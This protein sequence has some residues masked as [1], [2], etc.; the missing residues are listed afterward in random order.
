MKP[1]TSAQHCTEGNEGPYASIASSSSALS[2][3]R[4]TT[5]MTL[6]ATNVWTSNENSYKTP[7]HLQDSVS[8]ASQSLPTKDVTCPRC[9]V[10][11][12]RLCP[13]CLISALRSGHHV[14]PK[15]ICR[16]L[17]VQDFVSFNH[18]TSMANQMM[19]ND[20]KLQ[21][22]NN[23]VQVLFQSIDHIV[24]HPA[25]PPHEKAY[26][27]FMEGYLRRVEDVLT[28]QILSAAPTLHRE[29]T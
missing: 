14:S 16:T 17:E 29:Y 13:N 8:A 21:G 24:K 20:E 4:N 27:A 19:I 6:N 7:M 1:L 5:D 2:S 23:D 11:D 9:R 12:L 10:M 22:A 26:L 28:S 3:I 25:T 18:F 15:V